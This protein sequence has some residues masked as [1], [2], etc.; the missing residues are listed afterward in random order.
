MGALFESI[1]LAGKCNS[2]ELC[3]SWKHR[4]LLYSQLSSVDATV[5]CVDC[6]FDR[7]P[8]GGGFELINHQV[9]K[10]IKTHTFYHFQTFLCPGA[11]TPAFTDGNL[12]KVNEWGTTLVHVFVYIFS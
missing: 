3:F 12:P 1:S 8:T 4:D 6:V 11:A 9:S 2:H 5:K 10:D 7:E